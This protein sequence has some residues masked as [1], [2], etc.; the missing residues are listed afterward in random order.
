MEPARLAAAPDHDGG[1]AQR[2]GHVG[3][4]ARAAQ[5]RL[6]A[7][8]RVG[9]HGRFHNDRIRRRT[10]TG[11]VADEFGRC[12][13]GVH[14]P[15]CVLFGHGAVHGGQH[16]LFGGQHRGCFVGADVHRHARIRRD[17]VD[18]CA[19]AHSA[20]GERG[21]GALGRADVGD[22]G[23]GAAHAVDGAGHLAER[24][25]AVAA[26]ALEGHLVAVAARAQHQH[27][28]IGRGLQRHHAVDVQVFLEKVLH[29]AQ[30]A[31]LFLAHIAHEH[32]V[33][34]GGD[35]L[36]VQH[37][38]PRQQHGQAARVVGNAGRIQLAVALLHL[39]IGAR[40][41][42]GVQVGRDDQLGAVARALA[43]AHHIAFGVDGGVGQA[44]GLEPGQEGFGALLFLERRRLDLGEHAQVFG[45]AVV[46]G[47]HG[48]EQLQDLGRSHELAVG[49]VHGGP[50]RGG[51]GR[52]G[53]EL[54]MGGTGQQGGAGEGHGTRK[55]CGTEG[56]ERESHGD[57]AKHEHKRKG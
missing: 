13:Q 39:H 40:G 3:I 53:A 16:L 26:R 15:A 7:K 57:P 31:Q 10:A 25:V 47:L 35:L 2:H 55:G 49:L 1:D 36:V 27:R 50:Q 44:Q 23:N 11:P 22:L 38:E 48:V 51:C 46:V 32:Q 43:H 17:G 9:A 37:L 34:H 19:A 28:A 54:R 4:G 6:A 20:H 45:G 42:H 52:H 24:G 18:R 8:R 33:A 12:A 21:L 5:H 29:A 14:T 56:M 41:E 30:V